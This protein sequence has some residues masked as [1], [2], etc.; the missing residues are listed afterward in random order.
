MRTLFLNPPSFKG[1]DGGAGARYQARREIRAFWYPTWLA[2]AAALVPGSRLVDA[3]ARGLSLAAVVPLAREYALAVLHTSTPT[4]PVDARTAEALKAANPGLIVG[5]V[6]P[7]VTTLPEPSLPASGAIDFVVRGE[8]DGAI[9]EIAEGAPFSAVRG[10]SY[11]SGGR[12]VHNRS[13][14]LIEDLDA[15]P[16]AVDVYRRDLV[17]EDYVQ[18]YLL[19][20]FVSIYTGRGCRS[21]CTFC[22]WPQ[23]FGGRRYRTRSPGSVAGEVEKARRYFPQVREF[24]FDD[25]TFTGDRPRAEEIAR[26]MGRMGV[27]WSCTARPDVPFETLRVMRENGLR[28]LV[29]GYESGSQKILDNVRK[30]IRIDAARRFTADCRRLGIAVHGAFVVGLPGETSGTIEETVRFA[31]EIN[32]RTIQVSLATAYPGTELFRQAA[33]NGWLL[34]ERL[35][36]GGGLQV[37]SLEYPDMPHEEIFRAVGTL[38]RRF[39]FRP[40]KILEMM[41][42]AVHTPGM[43]RRRLREGVE[44]LRFLAEREDRPS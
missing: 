5:F 34:G 2:Q 23:T 41:A 1:F 8:I 21:R 35:V 14:P 31:R 36:D 37:S 15:L 44:F 9:R 40:R 28:T 18:G 10:I 43:V 42:E 12:V 30:G 22:L 32:P 17:I 39:Y 20:P 11:R 16:H 38:Y 6:G 19:H 3:P 13:R 29:V 27:T 24:F 7:H 4:F 33:E 25:D 26:R